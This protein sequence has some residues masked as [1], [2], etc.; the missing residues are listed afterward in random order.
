MH[1]FDRLARTVTMLESSPPLRKLE[2]GASETRWWATE[3][4]MISS[5]STGGPAAASAATSSTL[6]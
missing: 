1:G 3:S 4:S 2:T 5:S 6:Q